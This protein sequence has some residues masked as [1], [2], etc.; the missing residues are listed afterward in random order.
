MDRFYTVLQTKR[1]MKIINFQWKFALNDSVDFSHTFTWIST[2]CTKRSFLNINRMQFIYVP[3]FIPSILYRFTVVLL[4]WNLLKRYIWF[5]KDRNH[6]SANVFASSEANF[7]APIF[8]F[9]GNE[10]CPWILPIFAYKQ[11]KTIANHSFHSHTK[12][13]ILHYESWMTS[14]PDTLLFLL[15]CVDTRAR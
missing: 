1:W 3:I 8:F 4:S 5:L 13:T 6:F 9:F 12:A 2:G 15:L 10:M 14:R 7:V 11:R